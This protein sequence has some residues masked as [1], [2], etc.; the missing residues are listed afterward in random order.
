MRKNKRRRYVEMQPQVDAA[1]Q[2][3]ADKTS[4]RSEHGSVRVGKGSENRKKTE[5]KFVD[6]VLNLT[7]IDSSNKECG[8][9]VASPLA[10]IMA[11]KD[12]EKKNPRCTV[13]S[14]SCMIAG[15]AAV[16]CLVLT[17]CRSRKVTESKK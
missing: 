7:N 15:V 4:A 6:S 10:D 14:I 13:L 17:V 1:A 2:I 11:K 8:K 9:V 12:V 16:L 5:I 3:I